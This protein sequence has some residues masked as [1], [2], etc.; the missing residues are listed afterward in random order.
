MAEENAVA[1]ATEQAADLAAQYD[2]AEATPEP[3]GLPSPSPESSPPLNAAGRP[4]DPATG[5]IL[6]SQAT[7]PEP[8]APQ[9]ASPAVSPWL[10][11]MASD[12]AIPV[13]GL[14]EEA[15]AAKVTGAQHMLLRSRQDSANAQA[16]EDRREPSPSPPAEP[17]LLPEWNDQNVQEELSKPL[18]KLITGMQKEIAG[19]K[20]QLQSESAARLNET[21]TQRIDRAFH[22]LGDTRYGAGALGEISQAEAVRR[23]AVANMAG[24]M[25]G[26]KATP[27]QIAAKIKEVHAAMF[28][29]DAPPP[30]P[31]PPPAKKPG[32]P[33]PEDYARGGVGKPTHRQ[34]AA[35]Q[36]DGPAKAT[37]EVAALLQEQRRNGTITPDSDDDFPD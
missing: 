16:F 34:G 26:P 14:S 21:L 9:V 30:P 5:R 11:R 27:E 8:D 15:V 29:D 24:Q 22:A 6:P 1:S 10:L 17:D 35:E 25:A 33:T 31:P 36:P 12:L 32:R 18:K 37:Q 2:I 20:R 19:L 3:E 7:P 28:G 13:D 4:Y 23:H